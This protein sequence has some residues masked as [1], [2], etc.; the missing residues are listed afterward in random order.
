MPTAPKLVSFVL[1]A[2][3]GYFA[4]VTFGHQMPEGASLG[5]LPEYSAGIGAVV[6]W[7][8]MGRSTGRG[9]SSAIGS[10]IK[11][12]LL[13]VFWVLLV[14]SIYLMIKKSTHMMY[15]GPMEAVLAI[16]DIMVKYGTFALT[17]EVLGTLAVGG[18]LG[19]VLAEWVS[20][21]AS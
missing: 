16:F 15:D 14:F 4:A 2:L 12:S 8:V 21:R 11:T 20:R 13:T 5:Y 10:G 19:G 9:T 3:L 1:F 7:F 6:G 17:P 18:M